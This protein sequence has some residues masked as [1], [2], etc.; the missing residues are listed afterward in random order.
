MVL[1]L[2]LTASLLLAQTAPTNHAPRPNSTAIQPEAWQIVTLA[3]QARGAAGVAP[4]QWD[5]SLAAAARQHC[6]RMAAEGSIAHRYNGEPELTQ[7]ASQAGA[8]FSLIEENVAA[9]PDP[10]T[11]HNGWMHSAGHRDNLLSASVDRVGVAVVASRGVLYAVSDYARDVPVLSPAQVEAAVAGLL[12]GRRVSILS[13]A[14]TARTACAS[15]LRFS[16][17]GA[18]PRSGFV[19]RW[20]EADLSLLPEALTEQLATGHYHQAA[21][22]SCPMRNQEDGFTAYRVA[23]LLY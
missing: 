4:L 2:T 18:G 8:H 23:V 17:T 11:I 21:I 3:N 15:E 13:D 14:T 5:A 9:G 10:A 6:L 20:Q 22:G 19:M 7:R 16:Q 12:R 1:A